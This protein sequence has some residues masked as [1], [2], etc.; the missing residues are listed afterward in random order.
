MGTPLGDFVRAKRDSIQPATLGLP[1]HGR[2][3]SPGLRRLDLATRAGISV[4]YLTRIEQGRDR[5]PS[6]AVL[7]A[8]ADALSLAPAEREHLR[9]LAKITGGECTAHARPAPPSRE[10]RPAVRETLRLLEPGIAAVTN[11]LGDILAHTGGFGALM[12][13]TGLLDPDEP[14][15]TRYVFTDSRARGLFTDW[16]D[17]AD[18][19]AFDLWR[20]PS[21]ESAEWLTAEL[22]PAAGPDF[23]RRMNRHL[24]PRR[25]V[26][27][28]AHP[29]GHAL[30]LD[31]ETLEL[32]GDGQQ[33]V[34]LLPADEATEQALGR[35]LRP[36]RG[37]LR[38]IS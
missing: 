25:G 13:G 37:S 30:R 35:L 32:A 29:S 17:I 31:R 10:V 18:E 36:A 26:L 23:T 20:G 4:E 16:D 27:R 24:V 3:R 15:L 8:L 34:V 11:R 7:N 5:N 9:Y 1:D 33:I 2:R 21:A 6:V 12:D 14:N 28:L 22:A 19:V 38:A